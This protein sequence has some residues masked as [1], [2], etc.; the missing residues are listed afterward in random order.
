M[1]HVI[2]LQRR[3]CIGCKLAY[4]ASSIILHFEAM[5]R[6]SETPQVDRRQAKALAMP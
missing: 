6:M 3:L 4:R 5:F 2:Q 1:V